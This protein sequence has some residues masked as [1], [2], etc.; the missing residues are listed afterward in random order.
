MALNR[1][2]ECNNTVSTT[3]TLC[4]KCG[5][6]IVIDDS[7][8]RETKTPPALFSPFW[9]PSQVCGG[10]LFGLG[11]LALIIGAGRMSSGDFQA[12][13]WLSNKEDPIFFFALTAGAYLLIVGISLLAGITRL[14]NRKGQIIF[15]I[16][17]LCSLGI[18]IEIRPLLIMFLWIPFVIPGLKGGCKA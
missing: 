3:G 12:D 5:A 6:P 8:L 13:Q 17:L 9:I 14:L 18:Q 11:V 10:A 16:M 2:S 4:P 7:I 1:C 15:A